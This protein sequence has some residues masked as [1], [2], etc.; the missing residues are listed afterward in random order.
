[1][2]A[3]TSVILKMVAI[4]FLTV[5][6]FIPTA[7]ITALIDERVERKNEASQEVGSKWGGRQIL[8]GPVLTIPYTTK[9]ESLVDMDGGKTK[10]EIS[11]IRNNVHFLPA[12]LNVEG[13]ADVS[14][15]NRGIY[16]I[17]AYNA[18]LEVSGE[19][20]FPD[21]SSVDLGKESS[22]N[23]E[24]AYIT[25][26]LSDLRALQQNLSIDWNGQKHRFDSGFKDEEL[27][28]VLGGAGLNV[29]V[30]IKISEEGKKF[31]FSF[32]L[33]F[34]GSENLSFVP[35]GEES[36]VKI[37]SNWAY[38]NFDGAFLPDNRD[39][40]DDGF[41]AD[42]RVFKLNRNYPQVWQG[43]MP[44]LNES[45]FGVNFIMSVDEYQKNTRAIK[46]AIM[47]IALTF[48]VFFFIEILGK[49][50]IHFIH[51]GLVG[52]S[53][54]LFFSLLIAITEHSSFG[55]AYLISSVAT[56]VLDTV[57]TKS[58][59][60]KT[61][62]VALHS[63]ILAVVYAF[64]YSIIQMDDYALLMGNV[65]LFLVLA[66]VMMISRKVDWY[67]IGAREIGSEKK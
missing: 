1:M 37:K 18:K 25:I 61:K 6:L 4:L 23:F 46:Y 47:L 41:S 5:I 26:S 66:I 36:S 9:T 48:L 10:K 3:K 62:L 59:F 27:K 31:S 56:V 45:S 42:W 43:L 15:L 11:F 53:L 51:Y 22:V 34:N 65:G 50:K 40:K 60:K 24:D 7:M 20:D 19:F 8:V 16:D 54:V 14:T 17:S 28:M 64:I 63:G 2:D 39:V 21:F 44:T 30:P 52:L 49:T 35:V 12:K 67:E 55:L 32:Y 33:D 29:K 57:Y 58:V 38:P 13:N